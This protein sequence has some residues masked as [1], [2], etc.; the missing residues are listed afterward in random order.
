MLEKKFSPKVVPYQKMTSQKK[1]F[2]IGSFLTELWPKNHQK[3]A[4]FF[5]IQKW[6]I[7]D[8][9][10]AI[11]RTKIIRFQKFFFVRSSFDSVQLLT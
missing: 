7:F 5:D 11:T 6:L 2:E 3:T 1:N 8:G 10:L 4:K 9:F